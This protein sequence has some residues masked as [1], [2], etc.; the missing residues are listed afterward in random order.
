MNNEDTPQKNPEINDIKKMYHKKN[1]SPYV[2]SSPQKIQQTI[3][4]RKSP[5]KKA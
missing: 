3:T 1:N 4:L 2:G 5:S